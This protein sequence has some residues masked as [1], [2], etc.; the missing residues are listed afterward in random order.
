MEIWHIPVIFTAGILAGFINTLAGGGSL[1]TLPILIFLGLPT[2][3]ANGTNRIAI[4]A[5]CAFA[6]AGFKKKGVS[7]FKLSLLLSTPAIIGA[8]IGAYFAVDISDVLFRR[9]LAVIMLLVLGLILWNPRQDSSGSSNSLGRRQLIT[10]MTVFFFIGIYG[11]FIQVG[12]GFIIIAALTT[13]TKFNLVVT[14]SHKVFI[15][16]IYTIFALI[17]FAFN[18]KVCWEIGLCLA[19]GMGLGGWI[20]SHWAVKKGERW[21]RVVLTICVIAMVIKLFV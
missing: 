11:G 20:G 15:A 9:V 19:A 7:N 3:V 10:A 16:G 1:L 17:V 21:I 6:V 4:V 14:N 12:V 13:I 2:A 18:G 8:I 5:Q